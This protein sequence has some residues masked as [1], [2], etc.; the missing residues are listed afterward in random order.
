MLICCAFSSFGCGRKRTSGGAMA[1]A[2]NNRF[3]VSE[4]PIRQI[5]VGLFALLASMV[6]AS[7]GIAQPRTTPLASNRVFEQLILARIRAYG[8]GDVRSYKALISPD[9]VHV[10]DDGSRRAAKQM[11][12]Y[13]VAGKSTATYSVRDLTFHLRGNIALVDC[14]VVITAA[15]GSDRLREMDVF[16]AGGSRWVYLAHSETMV[17]EQHVRPY[18]IDAAKVEQYAGR[19]TLPDGKTDILS[20]RNGQ[21]FGQDAPGSAPTPLI[22]IAA[23]A[24]VVAG[25]PSIT[26]FERNPQGVVI[27]YTLRLGNG[28]VTQAPKIQQ[29]PR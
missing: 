4:R 8:R 18:A 9:F 20:S 27:G 10:S 19:Y 25:D 29:S 7:P 26:I 12:S 6:L 14:E 28:R 5:V 21:L 1:L 15:G 16:E 23:D 2:A 22:P 3:E 13:I 24:F 17:Q 11:T